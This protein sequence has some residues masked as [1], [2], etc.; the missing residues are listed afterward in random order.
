MRFLLISIC[1]LFISCGS[2][3]KKQHLELSDTPLK[4]IENPYFSDASIDYVYK[5]SIDVYKRNF[6]GLLIIKKIAEEQH[7]VA[8]TTEMGNKLFDFT[9]TEDNFQVNFI[10]EELDKN[11]LIQVL[12]KDFRVLVTQNLIISNS[13]TN[14]PNPVY[15]TQINN[16]KHYY[17]FEDNELTKVV[18]SKYGKEKV[19]FLFSEIK[20][21]IAHQIKIKHQNIPLEINLKSIIQ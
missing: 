10:L 14:I 12:E 6:S 21:R 8:F 7:R 2:Y 19:R 5:A 20:H 4:S 15:E 13:Y 16:K 1:F 17:F 18:R 3:P 11:L 9:F